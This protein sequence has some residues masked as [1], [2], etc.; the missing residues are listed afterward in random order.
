MISHQE[1]RY[2][3]K[4][5][6]LCETECWGWKGGLT[7]KGYGQFYITDKT[8][9]IGM[10]GIGAHRYA[11]ELANGPIPV[12]KVVDH[13]CFNRSCQNPKH[14]RVLTMIENSLRENRVPITHCKRGHEFTP[15]NTRRHST[16]GCRVC[17]TCLR[18]YQREWMHE[19]YWR[20]K[21]IN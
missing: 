2:W 11:Y 13:M 17:I 6:K 16:T 20:K 3:S 1:K 9:K 10:R 4:V 18:A 5:N 12:G 14:L 19:Y 21:D 8:K 7:D 15:D